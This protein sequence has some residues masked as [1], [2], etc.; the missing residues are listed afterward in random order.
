MARFSIVAVFVAVALAGCASG[1][2]T[3]SPVEPASGVSTSSD[4]PSATPSVP[5]VAAPN[6]P[7]PPPAPTKIICSKNTLSITYSETDATAGQTHGVLSYFNFSGKPCTMDGFP[8]AWFVNPL[9]VQPMGNQSNWDL[10]PGKPFELAS[11]AYGKS[12][13]TIVDASL[14]EGCSVVASHALLV[15]P[16]MPEF[17]AWQDW[18]LIVNIPDTYA[19]IESS[20]RLLTIGSVFPA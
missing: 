10:K 3:P 13:V 16:P 14:V 20:I 19:C 9:V 15:I 1:S 17:G 12:A 11:G 7:P 5:P 2:P 4:T 18:A 6:P 8:A